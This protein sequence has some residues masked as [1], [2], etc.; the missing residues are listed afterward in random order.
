MAAGN[1]ERHLGQPD[2]CLRHIP[3][4]LASSKLRAK[5]AV[6]ATRDEVSL[7]YE[8]GPDAGN[9]SM[10]RSEIDAG[11]QLL[12][13][14]PRH[15]AL[16]AS[17]TALF[18]STAGQS[19]NEEELSVPPA[20][21]TLLQ[22][23]ATT[24][25][26]QQQSTIEH[27]EALDTESE[28]K[29]EA[30][31]AEV[32]RRLLQ[33][34][35]LLEKH[36]LRLLQQCDLQAEQRRLI[37]ELQREQIHGAGRRIEEAQVNGFDQRARYCSAAD[38]TV[39]M[40][41]PNPSL[42]KGPREDASREGRDG[43]C[44]KSANGNVASPMESLPSPALKLLAIFLSSS[45]LSS[46]SSLIPKRQE[47]GETRTTKNRGIRDRFL[48][49]CQ[50]NV[51]LAMDIES[52][53]NWFFDTASE[54]DA[55]P[56]LDRLQQPAIDGKRA[57]SGAPRDHLQ[58]LRAFARSPSR[59]STLGINEV[60]C[61]AATITS[62]WEDE[63][64]I[65]IHTTNIGLRH[66]S[67]DF[68]GA[69]SARPLREYTREN[70]QMLCVIC[71]FVKM[72]YSDEEARVMVL[73][74]S[75]S[76]RKKQPV[77]T[78]P[79]ID[80]TKWG[81][82]ESNHDEMHFTWH[83]SMNHDF[84][85]EN[86]REAVQRV[87][88]PFSDWISVKPVDLDALLDAEGWSADKDSDYARDDDDSSDDVGRP[89]AA[90]NLPSEEDDEGDDVLDEPIL[91]VSALQAG[92]IRLVHHHHLPALRR[93]TGPLREQTRRRLG[94]KKPLRRP[95][96][97]EM[98]TASSERIE[99]LLDPDVDYDVCV[100]L[101]ELNETYGDDFTLQVM[102]EIIGA[103]I[104]Y[105]TDTPF[106]AARTDHPG[107]NPHRSFGIFRCSQDGEDDG[108]PDI[109]AVGVWHD[110]T[111]E[112]DSSANVLDERAF[113]V[114]LSQGDLESDDDS[115]DGGEWLGSEDKTILSAGNSS[116]SEEDESDAMQLSTMSPIATEL[117]DPLLILP[118]ELHR[119]SVEEYAN[120]K[121]TNYNSMPIK[122][123]GVAFLL[124]RGGHGIELMPL[125]PYYLGYWLGDGD[126]SKPAITSS[127]AK[128]RA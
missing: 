45:S 124:R 122:M 116:D 2:H 58:P 76:W 111:S 47:A 11:S 128:T 121:H 104:A 83:D 12:A 25:H 35:T 48:A 98:G 115:S 108:G 127:D 85:E 109:A 42:Q 63:A 71:Q 73:N 55:Q 62:G 44:A 37:K 46:G 106:V 18:T 99:P 92:D 41:S 40:H 28:A 110:R 114:A 96:S 1:D 17:N 112:L 69:G 22:R 74:Y 57:S 123:L 36:D 87:T 118:G 97:K 100:D 56:V 14:F 13:S 86:A 84:V 94:Q 39:R 113:G 16:Q 120:S 95:G 51:Q 93:P 119:M 7:K 6:G 15:A 101:M 88:I 27:I 125:N 105:V 80:P 43:Q 10:V 21:A 59:A 70:T 33:S 34:E 20:R 50:A 38:L 90:A 126:H 30:A 23:S 53:I 8:M 91:P 26:S 61:L 24:S 9:S 3:A 72:D 49:I 32:A 117:I 65:A 60:R 77:R 68:F 19:G 78:V 54:T 52:L 67:A 75:R 102:P 31:F 4:Q 64:A 66:H 82:G 107:Q 103:D 81:R 89:L 5:A 79:A 29:E